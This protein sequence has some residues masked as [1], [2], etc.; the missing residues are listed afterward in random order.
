MK[1]TKE[2]EKIVQKAIKQGRYLSLVCPLIEFVLFILFGFIY[3]ISKL[4]IVYGKKYL[5]LLVTSTEVLE[6]IYGLVHV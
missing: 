4:S 2:R 6:Q 3:F 1:K 5:W